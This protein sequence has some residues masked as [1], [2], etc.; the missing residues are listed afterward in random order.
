MIETT[1]T[2]D[3]FVLTMVA[4]EN[5][6]NP[7]MLA[8]FGAA[9]DQVEASEGPSAVVITGQDKFFSNGLDLDWMGQAPEGGA[10]EVVNGLQALYKRM[11]T[12]PGLLVAAV[13]GHAF[14]GGGMLALACDFRVM[15]EDR[16]YFCLPEV[17]INIPFT[18][19]MASLVQAKLSPEVAR[20]SMLTGRRYTAA[21]AL[22]AGI[23]EATATEA[24][25]LGVAVERAQL[26]AS[27]T[28][29]VVGE[30]K[31]VMYPVAIANLAESVGFPT[32]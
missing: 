7:T 27:K 22:A 5:R 24:D 14:A 1:K 21:E 11:I 23:V 31:R 3:V 12:F 29:S 6:F 18:S 32:A 10:A 17:D 15:R 13:N 16:G 4:E 20:E 26:L 19:G 8:A 30:I 28:S 25:V 2:D 9:L